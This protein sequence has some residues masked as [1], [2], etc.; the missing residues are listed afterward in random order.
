MNFKTYEESNKRNNEKC[1]L[2]DKQKIKYHSFTLLEFFP[3]EK[4]NDLRE[5]LD[6]LYE[7]AFLA[8]D[9]TYNYRDFLMNISIN[10]FELNFFLPPYILNSKFKGKITFP[11]EVSRDLGDNISC[12]MFFIHKIMPSLV[13]LQIE[14]ILSAN[15]S[16]KLNDIIYKYHETNIDTIKEFTIK[17]ILSPEIVKFNEIYELRYLLREEAINYLSQYFKGYFFEQIEKDDNSVVPYIDLFSLEY[18]TKKYD[19]LNWTRENKGF[20]SCLGAYMPYTDINYSKADKLIL[21]FEYGNAIK[22]RYN[23]CL[24]FAN[25]NA[26]RNPLPYLPNHKLKIGIDDEIETIFSSYSFELFAITRWLE[27]Q[28]KHV[29]EFKKDISEEYNNISKNKLESLI[30]KRKNIFNS[31]FQF[32]RFKSEYPVYEFD[33]DERDFYS[34]LDDFAYFHNLK[35]RIDKRIEDID[36]LISMI[37]KNSDNLLNLTNIEYNKKTQSDIRILTY[38]LSILAVV[39]ILI[40]IWTTFT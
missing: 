28:E 30:N 37:I 24:V 16:N 23:N 15:I 32:Q 14:V 25:S 3:L 38:V 34:I 9:P 31:I 29:V 2:K 20:F 6:R 40:I 33:K 39:Q 12:Y 26:R 17:N 35:I 13:I 4:I 10:L 8:N 18:P 36:R 21:S 5:G 22:S 1:F 19:I 27:I 11:D 7:G